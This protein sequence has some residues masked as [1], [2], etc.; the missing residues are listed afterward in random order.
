MAEVGVHRRTND[1]AVDLFEL[2][3]CVAE[4]DDLSGTHEGE[5]QRVEE[6][7]YVL[8]CRKKKGCSSIHNFLYLTV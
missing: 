3:C 7:N 4:G 5:I 2:L 6:E 1:F 8:P